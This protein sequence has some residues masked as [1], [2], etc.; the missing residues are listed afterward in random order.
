[1]GCPRTI[2]SKIL[3]ILSLSLGGVIAGAAAS[4]SPALAFQQTMT[5]MPSGPYACRQGERPQPI[6][7]PGAQASFKINEAGT[8]N[9]N[10]P[11]GL[12]PEL[13]EVI[14]SSFE[15]W[16]QVECP[17]APPEDPCSDMLLTYEGTTSNDAVEYSQQPGARNMNLVVFRDQG[18]DQ[19]A[20][21]MTFALTSVTYSTRTGEIVDADVE[22]NSELYTQNVGDPVQA[23]YADLKNTLTHEVGHFVGMDHS[24]LADAT[25]Y[26][27]ASLGETTKRELHADDIEGVCATYPPDF[28]RERTCDNPVILDNPGGPGISD[29]PDPDDASFGCAAAPGTPGAPAALAALA[30]LIW[31]RLDAKR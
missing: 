11:P 27:S 19:I 13:E 25:M 31:R 10:A 24:E 9:S 7:W 26:A 5:C 16:S 1:M 22:I 23:H 18:W 17:D 29:L 4:P 20:S 28:V 6:Y 30:L 14:L 12:S 3:I 2:R 8:Q 15:Q 21:Q